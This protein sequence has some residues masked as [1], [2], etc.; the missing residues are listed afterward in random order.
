MMCRKIR[1]LEDL[2]DIADQKRSVWRRANGKTHVHP[3]SWVY[4]MQA[5][6]VHRWI[7]NGL[8]LYTKAAKKPSPWAGIG[9]QAGCVTP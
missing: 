9:G 6:E 2:K 5:I 4:N 8:W 7:N 1:T 3:A